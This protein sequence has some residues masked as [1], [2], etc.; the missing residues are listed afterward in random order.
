LHEPASSKQSF[1]PTA[2]LHCHI[3]LE[4]P[5]SSSHL[6][7]EQSFTGLVEETEQ[8]EQEAEHSGDIVVVFVIVEGA[9][10]VE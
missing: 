9:D 1:V 6:N 2:L 10:G 3:E 4:V 7:A 5:E 8:H